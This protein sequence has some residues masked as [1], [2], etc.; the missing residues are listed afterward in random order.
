[1]EQLKTLVIRLMKSSKMR[2]R[3]D[4]FKKDIA[5]IY[6]KIEQIHNN[7]AEVVRRIDKHW[8]NINAKTDELNTKFC[9]WITELNLRIQ[10]CQDSLDQF[11]VKF[12]QLAVRT[13]EL[14]TV[15][16]VII[17]K[18]E[19]LGA[20]INKQDAVIKEKSESLRNDMLELISKSQ[21]QLEKQ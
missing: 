9:N 1:M 7:E 4:T 3:Q 18:N 8:E 21:R 6:K 13:D 20:K 15:Q 14:D 11:A 16:K 5:N 2:K 12:K 19:K 17:S 10:V